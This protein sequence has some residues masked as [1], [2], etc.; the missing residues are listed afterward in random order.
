MTAPDVAVFMLALEYHLARV[1]FQKIDVDVVVQPYSGFI[2]SNDS[3]VV[4]SF[5]VVGYDMAESCFFVVPVY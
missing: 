1:V 4:F 2:P 5:G 3:V